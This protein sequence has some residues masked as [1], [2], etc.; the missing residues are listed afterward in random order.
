MEKPVAVDPVG[1]RAIMETSEKADAFGVSVATGTQFRHMRSFIETYNRVQQGMI[2]E[3]RSARGYSLRGQLWYRLPEEGWSEMEAML[4][5]WVNSNCLSGDH[6]VEQHIHGLDVLF[7]FTGSL[8]TSVVAVGGRARRVTGDQYDY[9]SMDYEMENGIHIDSRCR[10]IDGCTNNIS[11]WVV[12]TEGYTNCQDSIFSPDGEVLW[13]YEPQ[14]GQEDNS[15]YVQE[16]IDLITAIRRGERINEAV[17]TAE[18]T[19]AA[20]MAR[21][22]AYTGLEVTWD[23]LMQSDMRLGPTEY[24]LGPVDIEAEIPVPGVQEEA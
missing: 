10:Q 12:G 3:I 11:R 5:D 16:H 8:P 21:E 23:E 2:G 4:R 18:S 6:I 9:F 19:L 14:E 13:K 1:V 22:S 17:T 7:W 20:I 15:P 24:A